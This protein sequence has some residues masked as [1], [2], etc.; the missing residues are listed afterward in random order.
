[1]QLAPP[2]TQEQ[3]DQWLLLGEQDR[4]SLRAGALSPRAQTVIADF[5]LYADSGGKPS[6]ALLPWLLIGGLSGVFLR[7]CVARL[8]ASS[9]LPVWQA[10]LLGAAAFAGLKLATQRRAEPALG[11]PMLV[12]SEVLSLRVQQARGSFVHLVAA[13]GRRFRCA[14]DAA[15]LDASL[16]ERC[17]AYW[18]DLA[19]RGPERGAAPDLLLLAL[20]PA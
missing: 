10:A 7:L 4:D 6:D 19:E 17:R 2:A 9:I 11:P 14:V 13:D 16:P 8:V 12:Q 15:S 18:V 20:E 1:V 3:L 5:Q